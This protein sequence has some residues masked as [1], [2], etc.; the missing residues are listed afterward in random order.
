MLYEECALNVEDEQRR[1][2]FD[3]V[4]EGSEKG[5]AEPEPDPAQE[6]RPVVSN[7]GEP[8]I[9]GQGLPGPGHRAPWFSFR[10]R[11]PCPL[12]GDASGQPLVRTFGVTYLVKRPNPTTAK[13]SSRP[14]PRST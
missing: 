9:F 4:G 8:N 14:T 10:G 3:E 1:L 11:I 5:A 13:R 6:D 12:R 2:G 7:A